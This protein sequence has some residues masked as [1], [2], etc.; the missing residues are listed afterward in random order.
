MDKMW[1]ERF[2]KALDKQADDF[3]SS[4]HFDSRMY[5]QDIKGSM[6]HAMM[7]SNQGIITKDEYADMLKNTWAFKF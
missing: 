3:N 6:V 4:I 5:K 2:Q 7:L 1:A